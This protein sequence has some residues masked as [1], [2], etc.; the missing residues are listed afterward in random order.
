VL[1]PSATSGSETETFAAVGTAVSGAGKI[2]YRGPIS[3]TLP[4][5]T[6]VQPQLTTS[7]QF[8]EA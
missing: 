6:G 5:S 3:P 8:T 4:V 1:F 2:L 7:T